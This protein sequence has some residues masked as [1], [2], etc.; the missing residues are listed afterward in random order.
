[1]RS[2]V[3]V[4]AAALVG[5]SGAGA[6]GLNTGRGDSRAHAEDE[7]IQAVGKRDPVLVQKLL[8]G[9]VE[10]GGLWFS[11]PDCQTQFGAPAKVGPDQHP[12]LAKC[13]AELPLL[14]S[15]RKHTLYSTS[16]FQYEPGIEIEV[17]FRLIGR[18]AV[19][20]I[21]YAGRR[22]PPT[23][24]PGI[25]EANR[26][27]GD[28]IGTPVGD[29]ATKL[30]EEIKATGRDYAYAWVELCIDATGAVT[31]VHPRE[32]SSPRTHTA[33]AAALRSWK[34]KPIALDGATPAPACSQLRLVHPAD[35]T[36]TAEVLPVPYPVDDSIRVPLAL[37]QR[38][39]GSESI[40]PDDSARVE[41]ESAGGGTVVGAF[42][43]CVDPAGK[44]TKVRP[45]ESTGFASYDKK[46][47][48][49]L[50]NWAFKP[51]IVDGKPTEACSSVVF[52]YQQS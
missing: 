41:L 4:I 39:E 33:F 43:F 38:L 22:G 44:A 46:I 28:P 48:S 27:D 35:A 18:P 31:G 19:Q 21:G 47:E 17:Q 51:Y 8:R 40:P 36:V 26:V 12:A 49:A 25:L 9:T 42:Q 34:F 45:L 11:D 6:P 2:L 37:L 32:A 3:W 29:D 14:R 7:L 15:Q 5:C 20:R 30:A 1:M 50:G 23:I 10:L 52:V 24:T 16:V 13:L